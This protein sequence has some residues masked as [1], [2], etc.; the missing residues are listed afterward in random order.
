M[1]WDQV[2]VDRTIVSGAMRTVFVRYVK[3]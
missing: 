3:I 1:R 2:T